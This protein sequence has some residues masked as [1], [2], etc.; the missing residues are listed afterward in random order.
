[1]QKNYHTDNKSFMIY[2]D[3]EEYIMLLSDEE[4]GRL[5]KA[6]FAFAKRSE[7]ADFDGAM[8]VIFTFMKN[9][10]DRDGKKWE[11]V[12]AYRNERKNKSAKSEKTEDKDTDKVTDIVTDKEKEPPKGRRSAYSGKSRSADNKNN[13]SGHSY[14]LDKLLEYAMTHTPVFPAEDGRG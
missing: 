2:K 3:W 13:G 8:K 11:D 12:C 7:E 4:A 14:N 1:M 10:F 5:F 9:A 6:L